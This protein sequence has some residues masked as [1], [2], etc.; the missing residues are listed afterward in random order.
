[1]R[2]DFLGVARYQEK[3]FCREQ[4]EQMGV[5]AGTES[6]GGGKDCDFGHGFDGRLEFR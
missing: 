5:D 1:M 6:T 2:R 4:L 3:L